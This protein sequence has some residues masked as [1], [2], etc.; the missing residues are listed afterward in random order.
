MK[1]KKLTE[2]RRENKTTEKREVNTGEKKAKLQPCEKNSWTKRKP[3]A[4]RIKN[5]KKEKQK[6]G[7]TKLVK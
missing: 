7:E 2:T 6:T 4:K 5:N 1:G 3:S